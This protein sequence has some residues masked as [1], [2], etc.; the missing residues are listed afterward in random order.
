[1]IGYF[2]FVPLTLILFRLL[3]RTILKPP[4]HSTFPS[5]NS[6]YPNHLQRRSDSPGR[7]GQIGSISSKRVPTTKSHGWDLSS[8]S[9]LKAP[10]GLGLYELVLI[11]R[12]AI[13][14]DL[15][16]SRLSRFNRKWWFS[17]LHCGFSIR[18]LRGRFS[19]PYYV[20]L[21]YRNNIAAT[22]RKP[23]TLVNPHLDT[24][25]S[26]HQLRIYYILQ[27]CVRCLSKANSV[28]EEQ[29]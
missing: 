25:F 9:S 8:W 1:M 18:L 12:D 29:F 13:A 26:F 2:I 19:K 11:L 7:N 4:S 17:S 27:G 3:R 14:P 28:T 5:L 22:R 21:V 20:L 15:R 10:F 24:H 6:A 23:A 16:L